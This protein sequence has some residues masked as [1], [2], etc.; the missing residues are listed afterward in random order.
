MGTITEP[1]DR[2]RVKI[3]LDLP[4]TG[5]ASVLPSTV[6][7]STGTWSSRP[8]IDDILR[9]S[10]AVMIEEVV[11][12]LAPFRKLIVGTRSRRATT[13]A[14]TGL[15]GKPKIGLLLATARMVGLPGLTAIP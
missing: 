7:M 4:N 3:R 13:I 6:F 5:S 1:V 11:R 10:T 9:V 12:V 8:A 14:L 2:T 15:P